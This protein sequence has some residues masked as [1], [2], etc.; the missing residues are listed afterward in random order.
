LQDYEKRIFADEKDDFMMENKNY[1]G[2]AFKNDLHK[3]PSSIGAYNNYS[4]KNN[5]INKGDQ[6]SKHMPHHLASKL[7]DEIL[8]SKFSVEDKVFQN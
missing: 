5:I 1:N 8:N 3:K 2:Y 4:K 6:N 7:V